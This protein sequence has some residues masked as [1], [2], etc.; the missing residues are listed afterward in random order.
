MQFY[1]LTLVM[2][3]VAAEARHRFI[4]VVFEGGDP[5]LWKSHLDFI[6]AVYRP[7]YRLD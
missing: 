2:M 4:N 5:E 3:Q 6:D 7:W 1:I